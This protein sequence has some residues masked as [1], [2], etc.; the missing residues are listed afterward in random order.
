MAWI[1]E[2]DCL[3]PSSETTFPL[4]AS[5]ITHWGQGWLPDEGGRQSKMVVNLS[6]VPCHLPVEVIHA[7][8]HYHALKAYHTL[9]HFYF[10]AL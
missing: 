5:H 1:F 6:K 3:P 8:M 10:P 9:Q 7:A 4:P 2:F